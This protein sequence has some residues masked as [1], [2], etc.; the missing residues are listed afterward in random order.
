MGANLCSWMFLPIPCVAIGDVMRVSPYFSES[1]LR[2][3]NRH[4]LR[5]RG[6]PVCTLSTQHSKQELDSSVARPNTID[7]RS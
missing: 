4:I 5:S 1:Q 2:E 6:D 7:V 3:C